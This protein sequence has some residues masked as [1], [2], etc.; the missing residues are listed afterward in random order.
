MRASGVF[1]RVLDPGSGLT[2]NLI[3]EVSIDELYGDFRKPAQPVGT[4]ALRFICYEMQE[5]TPHRIVFD[6]ICTHQTPLTAKTGD[7]LMVAWETDLREIMNE[8]TSDYAKTSA[9]N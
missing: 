8:I 2:P 5:G 9:N 6:K 4:I 7:A 1:G 3:V